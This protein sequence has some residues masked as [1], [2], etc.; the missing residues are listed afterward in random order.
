MNNTDF[1]ALIHAPNRLVICAILEPIREM[2]FALLKEKL[3]VSKSVLSKQVK[4]LADANYLEVKKVT[5]DGRQRTWLSL[6][7]EG[8]EA[9]K[10]HVNALKSIV[11]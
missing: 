6:T 9:Y 7:R 4:L 2:E 8:A 11:G 1:D 10:K 5:L 3:A